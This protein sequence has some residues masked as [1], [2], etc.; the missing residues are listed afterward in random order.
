MLKHLKLW[1]IRRC[2]LSWR[3]QHPTIL[4]ANLLEVMLLHWSTNWE[5][6]PTFTM[7][8]HDV[9]GVVDW[10]TPGMPSPTALLFPKIGETA[11][12]ITRW[13]LLLYQWPITRIWQRQFLNIKP[14]PSFS[15]AYATSH[16]DQ[17]LRQA[18]QRLL[19]ILNQRPVNVIIKASL[20][21]RN[22]ILKIVTKEET[23]CLDFMMLPGS[24]IKKICKNIGCITTHLDKALS[25]MSSSLTSNSCTSWKGNT[26]PSKP[27]GE[28]IVSTRTVLVHEI[29]CSVSKIAWLTAP[30]PVW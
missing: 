19:L 29:C 15:S 4:S 2:H 1:N 24:R 12:C 14:E 6:V 23:W 25:R 18:K 20:T 13:L 3:L 30:V 11:R 17:R 16:R 26:C 8:E 27:C 21:R 22:S 5:N 10:N 28:A 7:D 9:D